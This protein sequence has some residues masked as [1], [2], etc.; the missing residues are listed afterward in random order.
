MYFIFNYYTLNSSK[1]IV[2]LLVKHGAL[3]SMRTSAKFSRYPN[4]TPLEYAAKK[5]DWRMLQWL[6]AL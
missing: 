1:E 6:N 2:E 3:L 4:C 5:E